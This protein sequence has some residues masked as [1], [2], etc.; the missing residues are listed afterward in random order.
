[1]EYEWLLYALFILSGLCA[2]FFLITLKI[3]HS[4]TY[5]NDFQKLLMSISTGL[6]QR[7]SEDMDKAIGFALEMIGKFFEADRSYV[8]PL[9]D[10]QRQENEPEE[11]PVM[12]NTHEWCAPG[13]S[14]QIENLQ[15]IPQTIIPWWMEKIRENQVI[16]I[17]DVNKLPE[18][19]SVEKQILQPQGILPLLVIPLSLEGKAIGFIGFD[20]TKR[21]VRFSEN[22][23]FALRIA[24]KPS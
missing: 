23:I 15:R 13:V 1:M 4:I 2:L 20:F 12:D 16:R 3:R 5:I 6:I 22:V 18:A 19:A 11:E 14:P 21:R 24:G 9:S 7:K 10:Y 8:F 17:H